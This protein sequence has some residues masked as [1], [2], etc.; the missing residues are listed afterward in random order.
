MW[1]SSFSELHEAAAVGTDCLGALQASARWVA[2]LLAPQVCALR[3]AALDVGRLMCAC[4][5][6]RQPGGG[7]ATTATLCDVLADSRLRCCAAGAAE[8][9]GQR[10]LS[11]VCLAARVAAVTRITA[12]ASRTAFCERA[13]A[14]LAASICACLSSQRLAPGDVHVALAGI[15]SLVV[16]L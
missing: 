9:A 5:D 13:R 10:S 4:D 16:R 6:G 12:S 8:V 11:P 2:G 1:A 15:S 14:I 7:A 3:G